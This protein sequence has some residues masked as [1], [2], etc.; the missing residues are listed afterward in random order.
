MLGTKILE[1]GPSLGMRSFAVREV[2]ADI[3]FLLFNGMAIS[4]QRSEYYA[5]AL[6][7]N[8]G[9]SPRFDLVQLYACEGVKSEF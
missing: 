4:T 2:E 7:Q 8:A 6:Q 1:T 9:L 5:K 3:Q